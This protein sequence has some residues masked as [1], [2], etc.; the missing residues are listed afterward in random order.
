MLVCACACASMMSSRF[1]IRG[2]ARGGKCRQGSSATGTERDRNT[3]LYCTNCTCF[4]C[5]LGLHRECQGAPQGEGKVTGL[6]WVGVGDVTAQDPECS[7]RR[8]SSLNPTAVVFEPKRASSIAVQQLIQLPVRGVVFL[9]Y[10]SLLERFT[11][12]LLSPEKP[13]PR[14]GRTHP[15]THHPSQNKRPEACICAK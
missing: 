6:R 1:A 14:V 9:A 7:F 15:L 5:C 10:V 3:L 13:D 11:G 2:S 12:V 4:G 8:S